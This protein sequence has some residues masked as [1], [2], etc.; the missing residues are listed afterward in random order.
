M[1]FAGMSDLFIYITAM[2]FCMKLCYCILIEREMQDRFKF[3]NAPNSNDR[4]CHNVVESEVHNDRCRCKMDDP[5]LASQHGKSSE[6]LCSP[7]GDIT[8]G[9]NTYL[10]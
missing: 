7:P 10:P 3:L 1:K 9:T 8:E 4:K 6:I 5:I 2:F